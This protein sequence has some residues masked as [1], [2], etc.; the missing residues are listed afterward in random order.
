MKYTDIWDFA[1]IIK[2]P[3]VRYAQINKESNW[4]DV[5]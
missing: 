4:H 1:K 5:S 3:L 2:E